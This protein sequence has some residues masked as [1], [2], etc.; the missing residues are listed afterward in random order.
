M[1]HHCFLKKHVTHT[2]RLSISLIRK[3]SAEIYHINL[4]TIKLSTIFL[5]SSGAKLS[6]KLGGQNLMI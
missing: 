4:A 1:R 6:K 3:I 5:I 2:L